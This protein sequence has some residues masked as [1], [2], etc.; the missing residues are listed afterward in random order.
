MNDAQ[1]ILCAGLD[2]ARPSL[3]IPKYITSGKLVCSGKSHR[4]SQYERIWLVA[5]GKASDTMAKAA[6]DILHADGGIVVIPKNNKSVFYNKKFQIIHAGH[7]TPN[8]NSVI[9]AKKIITLLE[10]AGKDDLVVFLISGGASA[11][12]CAPQGITIQQ[13]IKTTKILLESGA[14]ISEINAIRKH[15]SGVKGGKMLENLHCD[16]ISYVMSDVVGDDL[17]SIASGMTYCDKTTFSDCLGI[18]SKH[19]LGKKLPKSV[20]IRLRNGT[21]GKASETPKKPK[22]PNQIIASN[23][24]C[25]GVMSKKAK[26]LGYSVVVFPNVAGD[27]ALA[28][29][30]ILRK[31]KSS[32][33]SCLIFGGETTVQVRGMGKGGRNQ[34]L[35]LNMIPQ[36]PEKTIVASI[37]TDGIDGNTK[38]AGAIFDH[39]IDYAITKP[40]LQNNDSNSFFKKFGGLIRTGPTHTNLQDIGIILQHR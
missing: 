11:L 3:H 2:A 26:S 23:F 5:M 29:Q 39:A 22:I 34:E 6:H 25:L 13:K 17:G 8:Q 35:V 9:A 10:N 20:L 12:V 4:V 1:K 28:A 21:K 40:Y 36:L 38:H 24:T 37:G 19:N 32:K 27:V 15:L 16:A 33:K 14:A 31:F 30:K 18:V 7:P